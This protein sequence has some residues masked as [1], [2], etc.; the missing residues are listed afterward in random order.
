[1]ISDV[2]GK[3]LVV[4]RN[5]RAPGAVKRPPWGPSS[6]NRASCSTNPW[7]S[8]RPST[9]SRKSSQRAFANSRFWWL[10]TPFFMTRQNQKAF[11]RIPSATIWP[12]PGPLRRDASNSPLSAEPN[13]SARSSLVLPVDGEIVSAA[14]IGQ[15]LGNA[16]LCGSGHRR[17]DSPRTRRRRRVG[18]TSSDSPT[19]D[20]H[21]VNGRRCCGPDCVSPLSRSIRLSED[22]QI[23]T[24]QPE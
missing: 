3:P 4:R 12:P 1:V 2:Q 21:L 7:R 23:K 11:L 6:A 17:A 18:L 22:V 20:A 5:S 24:E 19:R 8:K 16:A 13:S 15:Y 9:N 14:Q 10:L